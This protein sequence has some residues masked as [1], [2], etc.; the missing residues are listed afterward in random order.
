MKQIYVL[1]HNTARDRAKEAV[2]Q[3]P[4]GYRVVIEPP[5]RTGGQNDIFH[6]L[7]NDIARDCEHAKRKWSPEQWKVLLVSG[8]AIAEGRGAEVIAGLEGEF[9]NV[10][11]STSQMPKARATSL[12][13]YAQAYY[14]HNRKS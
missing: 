10:R 3:A 14:A 5:K 12:I 9:V 7:C 13:E 4:E 2:L 6:A 8:H 1:S 11:E